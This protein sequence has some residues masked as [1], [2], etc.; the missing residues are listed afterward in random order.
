MTIPKVPK[1]PMWGKSQLQLPVPLP[2]VSLNPEAFEELIRSQGV[3]LYHQRPI[4]CPNVRDLTAPDH[5][6]SCNACYNGFLYYD[7]REFVGAFAGNDLNRNFG[8]NGSWDFDQ[9]TLIF[10]VRDSAGIEMDVQ[11]FDQ[12]VMPDFTV[13]YY[14]RV[15]HSQSGLDRLQFPAHHV[16]YVEDAN[17]MKYA[18]DIDFII[19][20]GR[21]KWISGNRPGYNPMI[22]RGIIY[23]IN[24]YTRPSFT[25]VGLPHQLRIAQTQGDIRGGPNTIARFPQL[26]VIRKDFIPYQAYDRTGAPDRPEPQNGSFR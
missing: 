19:D 25:V 4:P 12:I 23:S 24:Y 21:I 6:P 2:N 17:G 16:D 3:R 1:V 8:M 5:D 13:R 14:Q 15:E 22:D 11:Y 10:P 20:D 9:A 7:Q 18:Q 26:C